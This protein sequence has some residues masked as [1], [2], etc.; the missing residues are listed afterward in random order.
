MKTRR[1]RCEK[2]KRFR[3]HESAIA[4]LQVLKNTSVRDTIPTRAYFCS[5][6]NGYHLTSKLSLLTNITNAEVP[7]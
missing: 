2:K 1:R 6:C 3:D 4:A 5:R 7:A